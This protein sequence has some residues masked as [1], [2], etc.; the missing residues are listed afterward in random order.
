VCWPDILLFVILWLQ[1]LGGHLNMIWIVLIVECSNNV[2]LFRAWKELNSYSHENQ[3]LEQVN[4]TYQHVPVLCVLDS[5]TEGDR[6]LFAV[7]VTVTIFRE[8]KMRG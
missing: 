1:I 8:P 2:N 3:K 6:A 4:S 7:I 5:Q